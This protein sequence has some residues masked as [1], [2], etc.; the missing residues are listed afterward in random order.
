MPFQIVEI[1]DRYGETWNAFLAETPFGTYCHRFEW[2]K[3]IESAYEL[4]VKMLS[5]Q[6]A[7]EWLAVFP[8]VI[9][10]SLP[11]RGRRAVSVAFCNYGDIAPSLEGAHC[12]DE[13]RQACLEYLAKSG[14]RQIETRA[15]CFDSGE[16]DEVTLVLPLCNNP[17]N[18][19]NRVGDKIRNQ[20]RKAVK[21]GLH[22]TWGREQI[23]VLYDV[24]AANMGRLGTPVH[25]AGFFQA[26]I[27]DFGN[28]ADVLA[29]R[30]G[31]KVIGA[32]LLIRHGDTWAD[33]FA[34]SLPGYR[35]Y[36]PNMLMYWEALRAACEKGV[37]FYD[38]GRSRSGSG[39]HI[40]K[41]Q[42]GALAY[43]LNY[44]TYVNGVARDESST[45]FYRSAGGGAGARV[46]SNLPDFVQRT[47]GPAI[48]RWLP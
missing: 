32:M 34:S 45:K 39:T 47:M 20:I 33:P 37:K 9:M 40:F 7:G 23:G 19:W 8:I 41:R 46:W 43:P 6:N 12:N 18:L 21:M 17:E 27:R 13:M 16:G 36:N 25:A 48:R 26:M 38:F 14:I 15:R 1:D 29:V 4:D 28:D 3:V 30:K 35:N 22:V 2:K 42:W 5:I 31:D 24:Y 44:L 10:P 11:G